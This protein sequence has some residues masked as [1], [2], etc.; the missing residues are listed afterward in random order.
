MPSLSMAASA[1]APMSHVGSLIS[2]GHDDS[3]CISFSVSELSGGRIDRS[4][5]A[6]R[7]SVHTLPV[8]HSES[9]LSLS[10]SSSLSRKSLPSPTLSFATAAASDRSRQS[11]RARRLPDR[12]SIG[13]D[14]LSAATSHDSFT[15]AA[16]I[17]SGSNGTHS[18]ALAASPSLA[19][20]ML[21][22]LVGCS[23]LRE[24]IR[25]GPAWN[26]LAR[27]VGV[28]RETL[29]GGSNFCRLLSDLALRYE[30]NR[31]DS[32]PRELQRMH[33]ITGA[34]RDIDETIC[35]FCSEYMYYAS[36]RFYLDC[37]SRVESCSRTPKK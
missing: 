14:C 18:S 6:R 35:T 34:A 17:S 13:R 23:S 21:V 11:S 25:K 36:R 2:C 7:V 32:H 8:I 37:Y 12:S 27:G 33:A 31:Y 16:S 3:I 1:V 5:S 20:S 10:K 26:C 22:V 19:Y 15:L 9:R 29:F 4:I 28:G 24:R 30:G